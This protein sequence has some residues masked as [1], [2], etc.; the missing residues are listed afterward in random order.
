[1]KRIFLLL[2]LFFC[3]A[4]SIEAQ[5]ELSLEYYLPKDVSYNENIPTPESILGHPVG[6]WHVSH[7]KLVWY[8]QTIA[9]ASDRISI[10]TYARSYEDRPLLLLTITSPKN[11]QNIEAI[12]EAHLKNT[13]PETAKDVNIE[14]MPVV[15]YQ[16]F[17]IHGN[18]A[19]GSNAALILVYHLAAAEGKEI[20]D[21]LQN[22]VI[23]LDPCFNPDGFHRFSTWVNMHK[24]KNLVADTDSREL[25]E[26][27]PNG[28]T[29]HYWFD[30]N[31]DWL[32]TQHPESQGRVEIFHRWKPNILTDHHEMGSNATFF[33]QPGIPE[34]LNPNIPAKNQE[35]TFKI[36]EFHAK[37]LDKI[38]SLYY[39]QE[40]YDDFYVGKGSTYPDVHGSIGILFEQ[41][42]SRGH[43]QQTENGLLSFPFTIRNQFKTALSTLEASNSLRTDLL[44][45][46][47][48]FFK[49]AFKK[50]DQDGTKAYIVAAGKDNG[51]LRHF[52]EWLNRHHIDAYYTQKSTSVEGKN[53]PEKSLVIPTN[54]LQYSLIKA[55]FEKYTSFNDSLFYDVSSWTLPLAFNLDYAALDKRALGRDLM[56]EKMPNSLRTM[57]KR[58]I[59]GDK[60]EYAYVFR[61]DEYYAPKMLYAL[62]K[63][64]MIAKVASQPFGIETADGFQQFDYG[65]ILIP[66]G[67]N[68]EQFIDGENLRI[69]LEAESAQ[70]GIEV[71]ALSTGLTP[72]GAD[73]GSRTFERLRLPKI[74]MVV[75][76]GVSGYDAGEIWHLLDQRFDIE[77]TLVDSNEFNGINLDSYNT[78]VLSHG[79]Y[80]LINTLDLQQWL[81]KGNTLITMRGASKW[82]SDQKISNAVFKENG[83]DEDNTVRK[84]YNEAAQ[85]FGAQYIGGAIFEANLDLTHPLAYGYSKANIPVFR[86]DTHFM[87]PTKNDYAMPLQ[88][89]SKPLISGY[90]SKPNLQQLAKS[91]AI[92]VN[93]VGQGRVISMADNPNFRAYWYGTNKLFLNGIF[94]GHTIEGGTLEYRSKEKE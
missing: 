21:L 64:G 91:A 75:G 90:I 78:L 14:E 80:G 84:P 73:L 57:P 76:K 20:E 43:L 77:I 44:S 36:G 59:I 74:L 71:Y 93:G 53:F 54:Q 40:S 5:N 87:E 45:F 1:M 65:T 33:F 29:N 55:S 6:K 63:K 47:Q 34:R 38:G 67:N 51:R 92:V 28:R 70:N 94:F 3:C 23:L 68:Q 31:R 66:V 37:A 11:H 49:E 25:N 24:S 48:S 22:T 42:S 8:M 18:E 86:R 35:L 56:G 60:S 19:S 62:L 83:P 27:F 88:Y 7:D 52:I 61:W 41:A 10:E 50:A 16:G 81:K 69:L 46:Q 30:L 4:L 13:N 72:N 17:S 85:R 15:V 79:S 12:R 89:T 2:Y 82:A 26:Q 58:K 32:L 9:A 39:T